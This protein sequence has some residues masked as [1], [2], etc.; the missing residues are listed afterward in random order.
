MRNYNKQFN[1]LSTVD[2][3][4][5]FSTQGLDELSTFVPKIIKINYLE[6]IR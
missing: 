3:I 6:N 4:N 2:V 5:S 1:S